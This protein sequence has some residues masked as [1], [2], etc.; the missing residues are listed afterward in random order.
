MRKKWSDQNEKKGRDRV[1]G[2]GVRQW[3]K[4]GRDRKK[5]WEKRGRQ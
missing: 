1:E 3:E 2:R 4:I 5:R